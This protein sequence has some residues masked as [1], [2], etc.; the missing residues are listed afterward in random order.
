MTDQQSKHVFI[1]YVQ[2]NKK[3]VDRLARDLEAHGVK[4]WLDRNDIKPGSRWKNAIRKAI[5]EGAFFIA[6]FSA[7]YTSKKKT[8][9]N[10]ELSLAIEELRQYTTD[11][12]WFIPVLL[13]E[14]DV[15]DRSIGAGQTLHD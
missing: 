11:R 4:V 5:K 9:M 12:E 6:C 1:S 2:E 8:Y 13:S 3:K 14:C 10:E 15:P 7:E